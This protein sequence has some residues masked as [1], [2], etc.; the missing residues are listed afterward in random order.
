MHTL[1]VVGMLLRVWIILLASRYYAYYSIRS[2]ART[3]VV[4]VPGGIRYVCIYIHTIATTRS[5]HTTRVGVRLVVLLLKKC[6]LILV[7]ILCMLIIIIRE[8][9]ENYMHRAY[10]LRA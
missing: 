7:C 6:T 5:I 10:T 4:C 8:Q 9:Q 2:T 1:L 3:L